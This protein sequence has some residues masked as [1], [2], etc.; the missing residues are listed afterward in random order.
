LENKSKFLLLHASSGHKYSI[1]EI[2]QD[3][4]TT[5]KLADTKAAGEAKILQEFYTMLHQD[6][7]R[8]FYGPKHVMLAHEKGAIDSL[9]LADSLLR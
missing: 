4:T 3:R 8:A 2:L 6:A 1:K 9:L 7:S 5:N